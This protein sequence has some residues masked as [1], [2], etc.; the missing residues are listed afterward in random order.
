M[1]HHIL[2]FLFGISSLASKN[3][4]GS[5]SLNDKLKYVMNN[6]CLQE[7]KEYVL[8]NATHRK[9]VQNRK[10]PVVSIITSGPVLALAAAQFGSN[11]IFFELLTETPTYLNNIQHF[12]LTI[13][14]IAIA[15][16]AWIKWIFRFRMES[17][18][19][20]NTLSCGCLQSH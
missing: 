17:C 14:Y 11:W 6:D 19:P 3:F 1:V 8:E 12:P 9:R 20:C 10:I 16:N 7:E 4:T 13:V 5:M 18:P 2:H 15:Y